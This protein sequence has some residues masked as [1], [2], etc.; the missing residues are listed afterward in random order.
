MSHQVGNEGM[1]GVLLVVMIRIVMSGRIPHSLLWS[2]SVKQGEPPKA[3]Q[4]NWN[5][6]GDSSRDPFYPL[7]GHQKPLSSGHVN[8]ASQKGLATL[9]MAEILHHLGCPKTT[10]KIPG[11]FFSQHFGH[12]NLNWGLMI[13]THTSDMNHEILVGYLGSLWWLTTIPI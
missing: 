6:P 12:P 11:V 2:T 9:L 10:K 1:S 5:I 13:K 4:K 7:G 3:T 8:S